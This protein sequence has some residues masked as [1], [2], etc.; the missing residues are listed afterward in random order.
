FLDRPLRHTCHSHKR[1]RKVYAGS[2]YFR[3][4]SMR[5]N[6]LRAGTICF[7]QQLSGK[8]INRGRERYPSKAAR[9]LQALP[10][11]EKQSQST[12]HKLASALAQCLDATVL[13]LLVNR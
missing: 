7:S 6:G 2:A 3:M 1:T 11:H 13:R 4:R 12:E 8:Q 10:L 5:R 9:A